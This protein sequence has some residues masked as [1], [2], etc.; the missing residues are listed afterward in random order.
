MDPKAEF[1]T[2]YNNK[3]TLISQG[4]SMELRGV[5]PLSESPFIA[6]SPITV[7][8][9]CEPEVRCS[10]RQAPTDRLMVSVAS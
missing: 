10:L 5:E 6:V 2:Y 9:L 1:S 7:Y 8:L 4:L 3:K